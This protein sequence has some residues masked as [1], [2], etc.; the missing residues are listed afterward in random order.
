MFLP[1]FS[2]AR[3][4]PLP[5][6]LLP[7]LSLAVSVAA[8]DG[9]A[10]IPSASAQT[11]AGDQTLPEKISGLGL[12]LD[13][14]ALAPLLQEGE[15]V[16][17]WPDKSGNAYDAVFEAR[18]PQVKFPGSP[19]GTIPQSKLQVGHHQPPTFRADALAGRP[20]VS[21][22]ASKRQTLV[23][24]FAGHALGQDVPGFSAAFVVRAALDYGPPPAPDV[25]WSSNRY[26][27]ISHLSIYNTRFAVQVESGSGAL[28][29][30]SRPLPG[31]S[32]TSLPPPRHPPI[33]ALEP[34]AWHRLLVSVDYRRKAMDILLDGTPFHGRL[35]PE[36][37][38]KAED[39]PSPI[40]GIGSNTLGEW[41]TCDLA[42]LICYEKA[43]GD[44]EMRNLDRYFQG[45]YS[46]GEK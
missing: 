2:F 46:L 36:S 23:L 17:R 21:F 31:E 34:Y 38:S 40:T 16:M 8:A 26:L 27:F 5:G 19:Y 39:V 20:A 3:W 11:A 22:A 43:L 37:G 25:E 1:P 6:P 33:L 13:A 24:D 42:E 7:A 15:A 12:W 4:F 10:Q 18:I 35:P 28:R 45:K 32:I 29:V 9:Q 14:A 44:G 41:I 30:S